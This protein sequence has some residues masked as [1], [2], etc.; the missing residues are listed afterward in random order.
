MLWEREGDSEGLVSTGFGGIWRHLEGFGVFRRDFGGTLAGFLGGIYG[1][2]RDLKGFDGIL[3]RRPI[4]SYAFMFVLC[5]IL[6]EWG[7]RIM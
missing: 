7:G 3:R 6:R 1:I 2:R 5:F 4:V